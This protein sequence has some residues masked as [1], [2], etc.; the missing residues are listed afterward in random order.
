MK[1]AFSFVLSVA[2]LASIL[3]VLFP[4]STSLRAQPLFQGNAPFNLVS[5]PQQAEQTLD[6]EKQDE[7]E[8]EEDETEVVDTQLFKKDP[9][10]VPPRFLRFHMWDGSI[11]SGEVK[12]DAI[13]VTTEFGQLKIPINRIV[14]FRPGLESFPERAAKINKLVEELGAR[15]FN[16]RE[17]AHRALVAMGTEIRHEIYK[18]EDGGSAER[19]KHLTKIIAEIEELIEDMDESEDTAAIT[20][21]DMVKTPEFSVVGKIQQPEFAVISKFGNLRIFVRDIKKADRGET[22]Q[23]EV[24]KS[25]EIAAKAFF[26]KTPTNTKLRLN[27][28]DKIRITASG[29]VQWTNWSTA[30]TPAGID[31]QGQW[32]GVNCGTLMAR[33]G[34][35]GP[36]IAIG[37]EETFVAKSSGVL[38]LGIAMRDNYASNNGYRWTGEYKAKISVTPK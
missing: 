25:V 22:V 8:A 28:G 37:S 1:F 34:K 2:C 33:I 30:S 31:N 19:K 32:N 36:L 4:A 14:E 7:N 26:Q 18:F 21:G 20:R 38:Y 5:F 13:D 9:V 3:L 6:D 29:V 23:S 16:V 11:V 12:I 27:K 35:S 24:K 17:Q 10:A 15:E